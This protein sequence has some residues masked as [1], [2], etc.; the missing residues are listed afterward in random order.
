MSYRVRQSHL[1]MTDIQTYLYDIWQIY[2]VLPEAIGDSSRNDRYVGRLE[3][4]ES[5]DK[6]CGGI[7]V[8][9]DTSWYINNIDRIMCCMINQGNPPP[10][11]IKI[12][13]LMDRWIHMWYP[14]R[15]EAW[16]YDIHRLSRHGYH[17][18]ILFTKQLYCCKLPMIFWYCNY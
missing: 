4:G 11:R 18:Y 5:G 15:L 2:L 14:C 16:L 10:T 17:I 6:H 7:V 9:C 12:I 8:L 3:I 13:I 1:S